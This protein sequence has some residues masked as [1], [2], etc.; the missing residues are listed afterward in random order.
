MASAARESGCEG[1]LCWLA[2]LKEYD[3]ENRHVT[4]DADK[5]DT[6]S[7][8]LS[9]AGV[10]KRFG[11][12]VAVGD[13]SLDVNPAEIVG[14]MGPNGAGKSTLLN[15]IA[16]EYRPNSGIITF[17]GR[18]ITGLSPHK[19]CHLGIGRTYQIPRPFA[20]LTVLENI[21]A[22][23]MFGR[24]MGRT[25]ALREADRIL[26]ITGIS[27]KRDSLAKDL[28]ELTR[29]RLELARALATQPTLI[30]LDEV[31]AG[32]TEVEI[33]KILAI[34]KQINGMD[35]AII[36]V[37]H[38]MKVMM[39]AVDRIIVMDKGMKIAEGLPKEIMEN[40]KVIEAYFG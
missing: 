14:L 24:F 22:A 31:A 27:D 32:L 36:L 13:I 28:L 39:E 10:T 34:L 11:G 26:E 8:I 4:S 12:L 35:I 6:G 17:K 16:G 38:V 19:I 40:R 5:S 9:I 2:R 3:T 18:E 1:T 33:P 29:K 20:N 23:A 25:A 37:E 7:P 15:I 21:L 30:I